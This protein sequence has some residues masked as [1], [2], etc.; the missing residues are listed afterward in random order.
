MGALIRAGVL[1]EK[2]T[3]LVLN[4]FWALN[5]RR[6]KGLSEWRAALEASGRG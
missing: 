1:I 4:D 6:L 2:V 3:G 5:G